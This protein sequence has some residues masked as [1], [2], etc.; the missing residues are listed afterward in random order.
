MKK[1][2]GGFMLEMFSI[3]VKIYE[4]V[5]LKI[6]IG[7]FLFLNTVRNLLYT[8]INIKYEQRWFFS[9]FFSILIYILILIYYINKK[10]LDFIENF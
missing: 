8:F 6:D 4:N 7:S 10:K 9:I 5:A 1:K 3:G 2:Y